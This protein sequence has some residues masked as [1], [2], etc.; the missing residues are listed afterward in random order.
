VIRTVRPEIIITCDPTTFFPRFGSI[1]HRD[2]RAA[3][4]ATL[5][6]VFPAARSSL[7]FPELE[8]EEGLEAH[9][10]KTVYVAGSNHPNV[11]VDVTE[12]VDL[13]LAALAQHASQM[14]DMDSVANRVRERMR[15]ADS[16]ADRPRYVERFLHLE[17]R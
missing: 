11:E 15:A 14:P 9:K 16:P 2:H 10:V 7:Y 3:G 5:D 12:Y 4:E 17:L 6:A 1:N 13:K 8:R